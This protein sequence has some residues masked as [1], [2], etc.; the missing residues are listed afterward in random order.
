MDQTFSSSP[1]GSERAALRRRSLG[2]SRASRRYV[3]VVIAALLAPAV[4][5]AAPSPPDTVVLSE[6]ATYRARLKLSFF[7]CLASKERILR[8]FAKGG[9]SKVEIFMSKR[10]LPA[11]WPAQ[12]RSAAGSCERYAEGV[13]TRPSVPRSRP[14]SVDAWWVVPPSITP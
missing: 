11:D 5:L 8:R 3:P 13:W 2:R 1:R 14:S 9:F 6:G 12:Y 10:E 7:Q 4:A